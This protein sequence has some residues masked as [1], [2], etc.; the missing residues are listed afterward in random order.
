ML[1]LKD[2]IHGYKDEETKYDY[3]FVLFY[4]K[5]TNVRHVIPNK[6]IIGGI[7]VYLRAFYHIKKPGSISLTCRDE[8]ILFEISFYQ[9]RPEFVPVF[10]RIRKNTFKKLIWQL[11]SLN[12]FHLKGFVQRFL[13]PFLPYCLHLGL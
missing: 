11:K 3:I 5:I 2:L 6:L 8:S 10:Y 12:V 9:I 1:P 4:H 7:F 13:S